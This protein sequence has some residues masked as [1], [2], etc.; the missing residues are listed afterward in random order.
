METV[1]KHRKLLSEINPQTT[2]FLIIPQVSESSPKPSCEFFCIDIIDDYMLPGG[3][4]IFGKY[5]DG[6]NKKS[7][8]VKI[9]EVS[10][11]IYIRQEVWESCNDV[12][13]RLQLEGKIWNV[14]S[15]IV[16]RKTLGEKSGPISCVKVS[17]VSAYGG[18]KKY[19]SESVV[20]S[21][22]EDLAEVLVV[23][24]GIK[25]PCWIK[26]EKYEVCN[27]FQSN[28]KKE[29]TVKS[30]KDLQI[31]NRQSS[32]VTLIAVH[33]IC[34]NNTIKNISWALFKDFDAN[35]PL[36]SKLITKNYSFSVPEAFKTEKE[37]LN[38]FL[39]KMYINDADIIIINK[40]TNCLSQILTRI[41]GLDV[42][43]WSRLGRIIRQKYPSDNILKKVISG[44]IYYEY[45]EECS[46]LEGLCKCLY[47]SFFLLES[48]FL[49]RITGSLWNKMLNGGFLTKSEMIIT[50]SLHNLK[51][52]WPE[53][54]DLVAAPN[55]Q[56]LQGGLVLDPKPG[57]YNNILVMD[58]RSLYP[59]I[60]REKEICFTIDK[61]LPKILD[62][63]VTKREEYIVQALSAKNDL[64]KEIFEIYSK[65][66]K[67]LANSIYG[68]LGSKFSRFYFPN[69]AE[70]ITAEGRKILSSTNDIASQ[71]L[72]LK[73]VYGDTDSIMIDTGKTT[74]SEAESIGEF[75]MH[76]INANFTY[77][78]IRIEAIYSRFFLLQKKN[79]AGIKVENEDEK[80]LVKGLLRGNN[81]EF[82]QD[83]IRKSL[84]GLLKGGYEEMVRIIRER[85]KMME[86][87]TYDSFMITDTSNNKVNRCIKYD[88]NG[89]VNYNWYK[90]REIDPFL[91]KVQKCLNILAEVPEENIFFTCQKNHK[92]F[93]VQ[94][95]EIVT[96]CQECLGKIN[97]DSSL[98][99]NHEK[100]VM[101]M[102]FK[103]DMIKAYTSQNR[104][105][106]LGLF[107]KKIK[108]LKNITEGSF[109]KNPF[110]KLYNNSA[111]FVISLKKY[112]SNCDYQKIFK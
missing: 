93:V 107:N 106:E 96:Y 20:L 89:N 90:E 59:N 56:K 18:I 17:Y 100:N 36:S 109:E 6:N 33:C 80:F 51:Y 60:V 30:L 22:H 99:K 34:E 13:N 92:V 42:K 8:C 54:L 55:K 86:T 40:P 76:M 32:L 28:C 77:V 31:I 66:L 49:A 45:P 19:F 88:M 57:L 1:H 108:L 26:V 21:Y 27:S 112:A 111:Y 63:L 82:F 69:L 94:S 104:Q 110:C 2:P 84:L 74:L 62:N 103:K 37:L 83:I 73:V 50:N 16:I 101:I 47:N 3:V 7:I 95:N 11:E 24:K 105:F 85:V 81:S 9:R 23:K 29:I 15:K 98:H 48:Y 25:G 67:V 4:F 38:F 12:I 52:L 39:M 10:K 91:F 41:K 53:K 71:H 70:A 65:S 35:L 97:L 102:N 75:L 87:Y 5:E 79:Y 64:D 68:V 14:K 58:F 72:G 46:D 78:N 44:R 61:I 43:N